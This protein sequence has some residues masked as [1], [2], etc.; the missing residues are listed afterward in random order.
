MRNYKISLK[1]QGYRLKGGLL[2]CILM[3]K[4]F[5]S[6]RDDWKRPA[7]IVVPGGGYAFVAK[8]EGE[9]VSNY[10]LANGFQTFILTYLVAGDGVSY[11]EQ[12][13]E[14]A[15]AVDFVKK[16]AEEYNVN[17]DEVFVVGFSAGGHLTGTIATLYMEASSLMGQPLDSKPAGVG[18]SYPVIYP[19]GHMGSYINLLQGYDGVEKERLMEKLTLD[20]AVTKD[21][22]P[23]FLW[24]T[25]GDKLVPP[26]NALRYATACADHGVPFEIHVYPQ[27]GHGGSTADHEINGTEDFLRKNRAWMENCA[28]FFRLFVKE[29]F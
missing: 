29:P 23:S 6:G 1:E 11:P 22:V 10:F 16:H 17:P 14:I 8:R 18:L 2:E 25:A 26:Q 28:S 5:D 15:S 9:P 7:V 4:P 20:K 13:L 21:T 24:S 19:E 12:F 3:D 27:G